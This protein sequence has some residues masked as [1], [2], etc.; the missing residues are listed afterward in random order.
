MTR[1]IMPSLL[2]LFIFWGMSLAVNGAW[3]QIPLPVDVEKESN[4]SD[5]TPT[6]SP[7]QSTG[8]K[9][10]LDNINF[11]GL[12]AQNPVSSWLILLGAI[13]VSLGL[14]KLA[15]AVL[16]SLSGRFEARGQSSRA[17]VFSD[18]IGPG[19]LALLGIGLGVGLANIKMTD[20]LQ[21]FTGTTP[22]Q[23]GPHLAIKAD[24]LLVC[25]RRFLVTL[26]SDGNRGQHESREQQQTADPILARYDIRRRH[27]QPLLPKWRELRRH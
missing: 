23:N 6:D 25:A 7:P 12:W 21:T 16:R 24:R 18:L 11:R 3:A 2:M 27:C 20:P 22:L 10:L 1:K 13:F 19:K 8:S 9:S 5:D 26:G 17:H 15:E 4:Q 14:G